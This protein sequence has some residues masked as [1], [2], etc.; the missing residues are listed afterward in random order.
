MQKVLIAED[1]PAIR[2]LISQVLSLEGYEVHAFGDGQKAL[3]A[4]RT[5]ST[6]AAVVLDIMMPVVDGLAL[7]AEIRGTPATQTTPVV[8]LTAKADDASTWAGWAGGC[9]YYMTKPFEPDDLIS[10]VNRLVQAR[11]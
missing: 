5:S 6:P 9:D 7:L 11:A 4:L 2:S 3:E 1:D 10:A 8:M